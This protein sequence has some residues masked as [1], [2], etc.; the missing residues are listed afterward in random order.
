VALGRASHAE[1]ADLLSVCLVGLGAASLT[2]W[3]RSTEAKPI[4]ELLA[5]PHVTSA[6]L[7]LGLL[8]TTVGAMVFLTPFFL[9]D[10]LH[11]AVS[12]LGGT[13]ALYPL[14]MAISSP[15]AGLAADRWGGRRLTLLG[16]VV[17]AAAAACLAPLDTTWAPLDVGWRL[18]L[19]GV[20]AALFVGPNLIVLMQGA[21]PTRRAT[22]GGLS[23]LMRT[24]G[25][26][27]GPAIATAAWGTTGELRSGVLAGVAAAVLAVAVMRRCG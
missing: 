27:L 23:A 17:I 1:G 3:W 24:L 11:L 8:V 25:F 9:Q 6:L 26:A 13:L 10:V 16:G 14:A 22:L 21:E 7:S 20:G 18:M 12:D 15:L 5:S 2:G 4:R 19:L